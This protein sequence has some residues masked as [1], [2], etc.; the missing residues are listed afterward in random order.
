M[1]S[2]RFEDKET[3]DGNFHLFEKCVKWFPNK[4][5]NVACKLIIENDHLN[6]NRFQ[7]SK[8]L[9]CPFYT[10]V[11][12]RC[13]CLIIH[14]KILCF[15]LFLKNVRALDDERIYPLGRSKVHS[16][17]LNHR[18]Y[19]SLATADLPFSKIGHFVRN[20]PEFFKLRFGRT[21]YSNQKFFLFQ[22]KNPNQNPNV[23][24]VRTY[25]SKRSVNN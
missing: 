19:L 5:K 4:G 21:K 2:I 24:Y 3:C 17:S 22:I 8:Y 25:E 11:S 13:C 6:I 18:I 14:V 20:L 7:A 12:M 10:R 16:Q 15:C 1:T 23:A 9:Y